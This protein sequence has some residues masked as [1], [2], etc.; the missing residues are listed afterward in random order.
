M[1]RVICRE[2]CSAGMGMLFSSHHAATP[3]NP[4]LK[5][6]SVISGG[7]LFFACL[8]NRP[9]TPPLPAQLYQSPRKRSDQ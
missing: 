6:H 9:I 8:N 3:V 2:A 7:L 4:A 1:S 5:S